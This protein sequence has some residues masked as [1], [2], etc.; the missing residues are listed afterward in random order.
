MGLISKRIRGMQDVLLEDGQEWMAVCNLM[1]QEA[2][3]YGFKFA[4]TPA[5]E[6]TELFKRSSGDSSDIVNKEMYTFED[7]G[8]RSV[9]LRPEGTA[10]IMRAILESGVSKYTLPI[11]LMYNASCYRYEKP[12]A[13]RYRE[14]FQFGLELFGSSSVYAEAELI[15]V[16]RKIIRKLGIKGTRLEINSI[17]CSECRKKYVE[18]LVSYFEKHKN[19]L[20]KS[21][22]EKLERNPLRI[23]DCKNEICKKICESAPLITDHLCESCSENLENFKK[24]LDLNEIEYV[25]NPKIV[26][27]LDYYT[28]IVFEFVVDVDGSPLAICGGGRYDNLSKILG[29]AP[30][31]AV[32]LGFGIERVILAMKSKGASLEYVSSPELYIASI[33]EDA[34]NY[35]EKLC[36]SL[37]NVGIYSEF[38][39]CGRS[40]K[41]QMKY[42]DKIGAKFCLVLGDDEISQ[43]KVSVRDMKT[44][45]EYAI[46]LGEDFVSDFY[47]LISLKIL[48]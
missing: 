36:E 30:L 33:G 29:G 15:K 6:H 12:Q 13:G 22:A 18:N 26:R 11:R 3:A 35:A 17:G 4:R 27:G 47:D 41:S 43:G 8:G 39:I 34:S 16:A 38:D 25:V 23:L 45:N 10:G 7:K 32:G 20:C 28:G 14:F 48:R 2:Q 31:A 24:R 19:S 46:P 1:M 44:G 37:R 5:L 42:A 40:L 21:C 9:S